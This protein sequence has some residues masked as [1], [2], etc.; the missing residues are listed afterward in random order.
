M[1]SHC[2]ST[3]SINVRAAPLSPLTT[4]T[5]PPL[6]T[7]L[8]PV[9]SHPAPLATQLSGK[10]QYRLAPIPRT[11]ARGETD[12]YDDGYAYQAG[13]QPRYVFNVSEGE[14]VLF[15][16]GFIHETKNVGEGCAASLTYQ[17]LVG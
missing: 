2:T 17:V 15:P 1:D 13:W 5:S 11:V 12:L 14:A 7:P 3:L 8:S 9:P 4:L 10:R 16:P 6:P